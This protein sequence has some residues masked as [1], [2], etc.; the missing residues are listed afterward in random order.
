MR[1]I[2]TVVNNRSAMDNY[3]GYGLNHNWN[4]Q[5]PIRQGRYDVTGRPSKEWKNPPR[6]DCDDHAMIKRIIWSKRIKS[7][8]KYGEQR[9][10]TGREG[11]NNIM[12]TR[13]MG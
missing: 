6:P 3:D 13:V 4:S 10:G 8:V 11:T 7:R 12:D 1:V 2:T 5:S 9:K